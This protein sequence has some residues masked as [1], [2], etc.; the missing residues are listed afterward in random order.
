LEDLNASGASKHY[1]DGNHQIVIF[2]KN[3]WVSGTAY[4]HH[5]LIEVKI[6]KRG[7]KRAWIS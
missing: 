4:G 2:L 1:A 7:E 5:I 3:K 6:F